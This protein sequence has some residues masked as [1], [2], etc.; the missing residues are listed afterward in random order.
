M[1]YQKHI[2]DNQSLMHGPGEDAEGFT[3][4]DLGLFWNAVCACD[5]VSLGSSDVL[6]VWLVTGAVCHPSAVRSEL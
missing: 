6:G 5:G 3:Q 1:R 4:R 2:R